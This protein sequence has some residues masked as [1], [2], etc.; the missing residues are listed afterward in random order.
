MVLMEHLT[1][2]RVE[3]LVVW[4]ALMVVEAALV[5]LPLIH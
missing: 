4:E 5:G 3:I 2:L 1:L